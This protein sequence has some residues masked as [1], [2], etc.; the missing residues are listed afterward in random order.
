MRAALVT[1]EVMLSVMLLITSGLL[2]RAVWR[3]QA[4]DPGFVPQQVLTLRTALPRPQYDNPVRRSGFYERVLGDV[5]ALPGVEGAA[6]TS[7]LPMVVTG[8]ITG[9]EI[10]GQDVRSG[11]SAGASHRWVTPQYFRTMGIPLLRGR[12]LEDG[13]TYDRRLGRRG[14]R[15]VR[16]AR[17]GP[18]RIRSARRSATAVEPGR[19]WAWSATSG[20][21]DWSGPASRNSTCPRSRSP[22]PPPPTSIRRIW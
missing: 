21:G 20:C 1:V 12:D 4:I 7:G 17:T 10:P 22:R 2:I 16:R 19:S 6:F 15:V 11:R 13:D 9:V 5:R 8:L 14:Q 3:V 18:G